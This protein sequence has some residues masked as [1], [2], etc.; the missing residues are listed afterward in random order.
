[1]LVVN[2][3]DK[4]ILLGASVAVGSSLGAYVLYKF[5][6]KLSKK[7]SDAKRNVYETQKLLSEYLIFHYGMPK[8]ILKHD[9]GPQDALDFPLRCAQLCLKHCNLKV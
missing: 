9:S 4:N 6:L 7:M 5:G 1:M 3:V 2:N 8:E